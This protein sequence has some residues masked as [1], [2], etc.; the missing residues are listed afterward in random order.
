MFHLSWKENLVKHEKVSKYYENNCRSRHGLKYSKYKKCLSMM[1]LICF[2]QDLSNICSSIHE[3]VKQHWGW[4]EKCVAYK[5][6]R[7]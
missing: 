6:K 4:V 2:K 3:K 1:I 7:L 5:N